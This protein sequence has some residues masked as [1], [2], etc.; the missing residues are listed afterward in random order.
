MTFATSRRGAV[1]IVLTL[2]CAC[3]MT[4]GRADAAP[5]FVEN[6]DNIATLGGSG[7]TAA[8]ASSPV[9]ST[10]WFEGN[11]SIFEAQDGAPNSYIAANFL[12]AGDAGTVSE[13][14]YAPALTVENG[15]TLSFF[16]RTADPAFN[17][18][19]E[20][21]LLTASGVT[22]LLALTTPGALWT[23]YTLAVSGLSGPAVGQFVFHYF[24]SDTSVNGDYIGID[25]MRVDP[26]PEPS[27]LS[28]LGLGA[29]AG[30]RSWRRRFQRG[31][32]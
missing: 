29:V 10:G 5:I 3:F 25:S 13:Y 31:D 6:F 27:T 2:L 15:D 16:A 26:V 14:L 7:W 30:V 20:V 8:N 18:A 23:E 22:P 19:L 17:D 24:V 28:L 11:A 4:A 9:G 32:R 1:R 12:G 21:Y